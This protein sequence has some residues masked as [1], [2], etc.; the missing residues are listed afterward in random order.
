M[1]TYIINNYRVEVSRRTTP[2]E[3][4]YFL[5]ACYDLKTGRRTGKT[6]TNSPQAAIDYFTK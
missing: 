6:L 3:T 2:G 1:T 5:I 4:S